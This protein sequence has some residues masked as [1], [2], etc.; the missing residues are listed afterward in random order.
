MSALFLVSYFAAALALAFAGQVVVDFIA[1][2]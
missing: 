2:D 1:R